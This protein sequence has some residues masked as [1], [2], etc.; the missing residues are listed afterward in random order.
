[1]NWTIV[2]G[3]WS[4]IEHTK[5]RRD[6]QAVLKDKF[7]LKLAHNISGSDSPNDIAARI[8]YLNEE[9]ESYL[10]AFIHETMDLGFA[11]DGTSRLFALE[12]IQEQFDIDN[13]V[14]DDV[15]PIILSD[16][17]LITEVGDAA[18]QLN[19]AYKEQEEKGFF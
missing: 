13:H 3:L 16:E 14:M 7:I 18:M 11:D 17:K 5:L 19:K 8:V 6:L 12:R 4:N 1:M 2:V 10:K 15:V 9:F